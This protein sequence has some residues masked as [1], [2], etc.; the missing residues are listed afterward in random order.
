[1]VNVVAKQR[2][3]AFLFDFGG[4]FTESPFTAVEAFG[5]S[6]GADPRTVSD[7]VFGSYAHDGEHPWH[8]LERGE[9]SLEH[10]RE[11]ILALGHERGLRV[12]LLE[13]FSRMAAADPQA[14]S[15]LRAELVELVREL[16]GDGYRTG[17]ITNNVREFGNVWRTLIPVDEL[18]EFVVDSSQVGARKPDRRIFEIALDALGGTTPAECVFLDDHPAN[19]EA[20]IALGMQG[21]LVGPN[22]ARTVDDIRRLII[23]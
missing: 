8:R 16:R 6:I 19:V 18:F 7:I 20:A 15:G 2:P 11:L 22:P 23:G 4:V 10:S 13:L 21:L 17:M 1:M 14:G 9:I 5:R 3:R 12:D